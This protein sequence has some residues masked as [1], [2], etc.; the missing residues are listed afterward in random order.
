M[1]L[2]IVASNLE[3]QNQA[4]DHVNRR[5]AHR[6]AYFGIGPVLQTKRH[7]TIFEMEG[8]RRFRSYGMPAIRD[9]VAVL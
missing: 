2:A 8:T 7:C 3:G 6:S 1:L 4:V 5:L 9:P